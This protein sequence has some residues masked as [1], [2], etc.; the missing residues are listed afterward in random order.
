M[1]MIKLSTAA[2]LVAVIGNF[3]HV[4]AQIHYQLERT[5]WEHLWD[6][7]LHKDF[8]AFVS[9]S[10]AINYSYELDEFEFLNYHVR[11]DTII[12]TTCNV[13]NDVFTERPVDSITY[14]YEKENN[15][16]ILLQSVFH[17]ADGQSRRLFSNDSYILY[18]KEN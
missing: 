10:K 17:C 13:S 16:L 2:V 11:N 7:N 8:I 12:M 4:A 5:I 3:S 15:R 1:K 14:Y 6:N 18:K 9:E